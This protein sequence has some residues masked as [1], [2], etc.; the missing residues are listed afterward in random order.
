MQYTHTKTI[1]VHKYNIPTQYNI[2]SQLR[3]AYTNTI[4][5]HTRFRT[6]SHHFTY[7]HTFHFTSLHLFT[8]FT[9][10]HLFTQ[11]FTSSHLYTLKTPLEF[12]LF[13]TTSLTL[14]L[15]GLNLQGKDASKS[16]GSWFQS[17]TVLFTN[18]YL[19]TSVLCFLVLISCYDR[20]YLGSMVL[21]VC[22]Q[23]LSKPAPWCM[24][25]TE[26]TFLLSLCAVALFPNPSH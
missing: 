21:E 15:K 16:A 18:K 10:L 5:P 25:W 17:V 2:P 20:P 7:L 1:Y 12:P 23:S 19:P 11:H 13:I 9:S 6:P 14:F 22:P 8:H 26:R 3:Y 4:Y 24:P